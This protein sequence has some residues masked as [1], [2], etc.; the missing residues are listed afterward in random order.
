MK[1][2]LVYLT[3]FLLA[4]A[5]M[6]TLE[7]CGKS[8]PGAPIA[9]PIPTAGSRPLIGVSVKPLPLSGEWRFSID[10]R[11]VGEKQQWYGAEFDDGEWPL[12]NVPHT[13][14]VMPGYTDYEGLAW[15]RK[16]FS[17]P[18]AAKDA[19]LS[20]HFE[21][22]FYL[23]R[24]WMNGQFVGQHEGGYT[25]FDFDVSQ[26]ALAGQLNT[27]AVQVD[28]LRSGDRLP[29]DLDNGWSFDW[30]NFGGLT[31]DVSLKMT[32]RAYIARQQTVST[33]HLTAQ[34]AADTATVNSAVT[35]DNTSSD[36]LEGTLF[37]DLLDDVTSRSALAGPVSAALTIPPG[38][39]VDVQ[40]TATLASPRLWHFDH[41][42]LYR[43]SVSLKTSAGQLLDTGEVTLGIRSIELK[44]GYFY[45]NGERV[46]LVGV[47]R[48]A[49]A[50]AQGSAESVTAMAADY[51]DLKLLNE[52]LSRPV[53]Y[54]QNEFILD[55]A[56]R[57]GILLI[58]EVPAWQLSQ[59]Q[60]DSQP[61]RELVQQQLREMIQADFNHASVW[62]WSVGNE[63]ES[64]TPAGIRFVKDMIAYVKNIDPTRPVGFASNR[65]YSQPEYDATA[66]SD[67][68]L[69]NQ[70]CGTWGGPKQSLGPDLDRIHQAWPDK[71]VIISEYG[72]E[73]HWNANW[74]PPA[75][76]LNAG[77]Y[78]FIPDGTPSTSE[79]ADA[80][81]QQLIREQMSTY[82][83]KPFVSGAIFWTYQDYRTLTNF[84]MGLV[85]ANRNRRGSWTVLQDE[86][87]PA[88]I[89]SLAFSPAAGSRRT[90]RVNF[91]SRGPVEVEMPAYTLRGYN[92]Q[93]AITSPDAAKVFSENSIFLP[94]LAPGTHG[95]SEFEFMEPSDDYIVTVS[96]M[97]PTGFSITERSFDRDGTLIR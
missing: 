63:I 74:G 75:S 73:P 41:P 72:F 42:N 83:S 45:L 55:Y 70:Y 69:M 67:F 51:E 8:Q 22:V 28:N 80:I 93:W 15:Y 9:A 29:A 14:N 25:P 61:M 26:V 92:L 33:P 24:V 46:R 94:D 34:D 64:N 66:L 54:P 17:I 1:K 76:T 21:A 47:T 81:R 79:E 39:R 6:A 43:W 20:L 65:L 19:R 52:V 30:Y 87:A 3:R 12:V 53:H 89:D 90:V 59:Q 27:L 68:V 97:R 71:V 38:G 23:A 2:L 62:A 48:H 18:T 88:L 50:P 91:H 32:S 13:W 77:E 86:Y 37:A 49:D 56:D 11:K 44:D 36:T 40:L 96:L 58:P 31:R 84:I 95:S 7:S 16:S 82:R 85:D 78:Y 4:C 5:C 60:M 57:H 35:I 10:R